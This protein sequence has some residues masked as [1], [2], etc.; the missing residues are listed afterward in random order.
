MTETLR[1]EIRSKLTHVFNISRSHEALPCSHFTL[2]NH[3]SLLLLPISSKLIKRFKPPLK[4]GKVWTDEA[5][6]ALKG[7]FECT[8]WH[9]LRDAATWKTTSVLSTIH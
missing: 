8:D 6:A 9:T 5:T 3:N 1:L 2:S 7:C 4:S